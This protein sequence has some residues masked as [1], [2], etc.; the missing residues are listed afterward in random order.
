MTHQVVGE[1][2]P[3]VV[4]EGL[5]WV[6]VTRGLEL[7]EPRRAREVEADPEEPARGKDAAS[8]LLSGVPKS[9]RETH[10][11]P[12]GATK[13]ATGTWSGLMVAGSV[14]RGYSATP[15]HPGT[16]LAYCS[17]GSATNCLASAAHMM[18][19]RSSYE[20]RRLDSHWR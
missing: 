1:R 7:A 19:R 2:L 15:S 5:L 11:P 16:W 4:H 14:P 18:L 3:H 8:A 12:A 10:M 6:L 13:D 9:E 20:S 17:A